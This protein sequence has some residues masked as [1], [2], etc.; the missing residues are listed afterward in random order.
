MVWSY[1]SPAAEK[2]GLSAGRRFQV[3]NP[4]KRNFN[5]CRAL[6]SFNKDYDPRMPLI[7]S[8]P[9][10]HRAAS[11]RGGGGAAMAIT[12]F[13]RAIFLQRDS[14]FPKIKIHRE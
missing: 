10:S 5:Q 2:A 14:E 12:E 8:H 13:Q 7:V 9:G 4:L 1:A 11:R 3:S 6:L